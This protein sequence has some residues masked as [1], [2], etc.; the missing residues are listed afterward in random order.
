MIHSGGLGGYIADIC[1]LGSTLCPN[2]PAV[3]A[4][5]PD[6]PPVQLHASCVWSK[7]LFL[8]LSLSIARS[9][10]RGG[11]KGPLISAW[12]SLSNIQA[13]PGQ[14]G[15]L[16]ILG[17]RR[18][19]G[20]RKKDREMRGGMLQREIPWPFQ[21]VQR[22]LD[23]Q[24]SLQFPTSPP[25]R[26]TGGLIAQ[27]VERRV[28]GKEAVAAQ[29]VFVS[30]FPLKKGATLCLF[31]DSAVCLSLSWSRAA[32]TQGC[33]IKQGTPVEPQMIFFQCKYV[34]HIAWGI[35]MIIHN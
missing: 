26:Q 8:R 31:P 34:P 28:L 15:A 33:Q 17:Q 13:E 25:S 10:G 9:P 16:G 11:L 1:I 30:K 12:T 18:D 27:Q 2:T 5:W 7:L 3:L 21:C 4:T 19:A 23:G 22:S 6:I 24:L 14:H 35:I 20:R 29:D 32:G